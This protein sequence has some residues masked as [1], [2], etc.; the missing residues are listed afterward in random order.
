MATKAY[1]LI[2]TAIGRTQQVVEAL[3]VVAPSVAN[4]PLRQ[5]LDGAS[6]HLERGG[7]LAGALSEPRL[8]DSEFRR[9]IEV[10]EASGELPSVLTQVGLRRERKAQRAI[11]HLA[12][13]LEP[14]SILLL[15][16]VIGVLAMAA[17]LPLVKLQEVL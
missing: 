7:T 17:V 2:E 6:L 15:A 1:V 16:A 9:L 4:P 3:R 5:A 12:S 8:F 14:A 11:E 10:G 13:L